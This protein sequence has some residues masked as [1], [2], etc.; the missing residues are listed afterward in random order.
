MHLVD[1]ERCHYCGRYFNAGSIVETYKIPKCPYCGRQ[2]YDG[3]PEWKDIKK[4]WKILRRKR[5]H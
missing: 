4:L 3:S 5:K 2:I 1:I